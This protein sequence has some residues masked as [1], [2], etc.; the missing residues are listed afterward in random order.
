MVPALPAELLSIIHHSLPP[1]LTST[2]ASRITQLCT[3]SLVSPTF[4]AFAQPLLLTEVHISKPRQLRALLKVLRARGGG[5]RVKRVFV[6]LPNTRERSGS[7]VQTLEK[8]W[9]EA[10]PALLVLCENVE[11]IPLAW[12]RGEEVCKAL[13]KANRTS[14][15]QHSSPC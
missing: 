9:S 6:S 1:S 7:K 13:A 5:E 12:M 2:H 14:I 10:V 3:L 11:E 15:P 4:R 8:A